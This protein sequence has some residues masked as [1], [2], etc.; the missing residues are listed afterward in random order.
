[1][2]HPAMRWRWRREVQATLAAAW[3]H[4]LRSVAVL[5]T[6]LAVWGLVGG[7]TWALLDVL[8]VAP[9]IF[10]R[11]MVIDLLLALFFLVI[12]ALATPSAAVLTWSRLFAGR[13]AAFHAC[14]PLGDRQL[15]AVAAIEGATLALWAT[16]VL[17]TPVVVLLATL[18]TT[19]WSAL[20]MLVTTGSFLALLAALALVMAVSLGRLLPWWRRHARWSLTVAVVALAAALWGLVQDMPR[21]DAMALITDALARF[22]FAYHAWLPSRWAQ[23]GFRAALDGDVHAMLLANGRL[24]AL[25]V[26]L[27]LAAW[28]CAGTWLRRDLDRLAVRDATLPGE[29][30]RSRAWRRWWPLPADIALLVQKDLRLLWRDPAQVVQVAAFHALLAGYLLLLPRIGG[31]WMEAEVWRR[32]V[33]LF[34]LVAVAMALGTFTARFVF[35]LPS[36][37][38]R[39]AWILALAPWPRGRVVDA[40][41]L[42]GLLVAAP[43]TTALTILSGSMLGLAPHLIAYQACVALCAACGLVAV[44]IGLGSRF[45]DPHCEDPARLASSAGGTV[46]LF[47]SLLLLAALLGGAVL[48]L[49]VRSPWA[50][51]GGMGW[52]VVVSALWTWVFLALAKRTTRDNLLP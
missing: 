34:N 22:R 44:A 10:F 30:R 38:G 48:P 52:T 19:W 29:R 39:S 50:W 13:G 27:W 5:I 4:R 46:N 18:G 21:Q 33:S 42:S 35:P 40:M 45:A 24:L 12:L 37:E 51:W 7:I 9:F 25:A 20:G 1:M 31:F 17:V 16:L 32:A 23:L 47:A 14:L 49:F 3:Q 36:R 41:F 2:I 6:L 43:T 15:S 28:W 11:G 8:A 26:P